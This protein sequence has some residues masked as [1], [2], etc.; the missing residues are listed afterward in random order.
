MLPEAS[1]FIATENA[2][3][4]VKTAAHYIT[5]G[6]KNDGVAAILEELFGV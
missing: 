2:S 1:C 6:A 4:E 5:L 3:A